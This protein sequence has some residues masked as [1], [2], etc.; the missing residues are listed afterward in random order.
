MTDGHALPI[1]RLELARTE[2][3]GVALWLAGPAGPGG[4]PEH[5]W[6]TL[7]S[8]EQDRANRF[9]HARDRTLFALTRAVLRSLLSAATLVPANKILFTE[10][11]YGKPRLAGIRGPLFNVSHSGSWA[12]IGLSDSRPIGVDI[13]MMRRAGG[14]LALARSFFSD[15][16]YRALEGQENGVMF[17]SFY[18]IWTCKEAVLK[19]LGAGISEHLKDF[20]VELSKERYAIHPESHCVL[21]LLTSVAASPVEV[22]AGYAGCYALA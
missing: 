13:E 20:S 9:I 10:E 17:Q 18:K 11:P 4:V 8:T 12:L 6:T 22:P 15:A 5:L 1:K 2:G 14:E 21:P 16:E 3:A 19:A 7:S